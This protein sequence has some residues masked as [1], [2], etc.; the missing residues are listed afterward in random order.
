MPHQ[1][2]R[3]RP[4]DVDVDAAVAARVEQRVELDA[5]PAVQKVRVHGGGGGGGAQIGRDEGLEKVERVDPGDA[6]D[7]AG[8]EAAGELCRHLWVRGGGKGEALCGG[9]VGLVAE[10]GEM[11]LRMGLRGGCRCRNWP[12]QDG[13]MGV[14]LVERI[15]EDLQPCDCVRF[16]ITLG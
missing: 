12:H 9:G 10:G 1:P 15:W 4:C 3:A 13:W 14:W 16:S 2:R 11:G 5:A 8:E 7:A 6:H